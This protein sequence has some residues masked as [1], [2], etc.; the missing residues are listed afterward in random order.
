MFLLIAFLFGLVCYAAPSHEQPAGFLIEDVGDLR[1]QSDF[2]VQFLEMQEVTFAY[3]GNGSHPSLAISISN[4][5]VNC[6]F[7]NRLKDWKVNKQNT[8]YGYPFGADYYRFYS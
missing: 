5:V 7:I 4:P 2:A 1:S 3:I 8:N 6:G